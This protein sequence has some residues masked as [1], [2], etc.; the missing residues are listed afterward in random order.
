MG[1]HTAMGNFQDM[2]TTAFRLAVTLLVPAVVWTTL[3]AGL[4]QL[5]RDEVSRV[6]VRRSSHTLARESAG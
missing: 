4:Y 2:L 1:V 6:R 5:V 3:V